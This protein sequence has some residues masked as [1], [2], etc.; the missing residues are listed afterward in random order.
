VSSIVWGC[1]SKCNV[2]GLESSAFSQARRACNVE[3]EEVLRLTRRE[4]SVLKKLEELR[5]KER[6]CSDYDKSDGL[7]NRLAITSTV[8][9]GICGRG[10]QEP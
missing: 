8:Q 3:G 6:E 4:A 9:T 7:L 5:W 1:T 2:K 10:W